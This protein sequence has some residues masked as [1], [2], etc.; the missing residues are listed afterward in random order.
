M[1]KHEVDTFFEIITGTIRIEGY[2]KGINTDTQAIYQLLSQQ[3]TLSKNSRIL[4]FGAGGVANSIALKLAE[5]Q[6]QITIVNQAKKK[7][8][9]WL[10]CVR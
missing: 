10:N 6:S 4:I 2:W 9:D 1:E 5:L 7:H 3:H 8:T